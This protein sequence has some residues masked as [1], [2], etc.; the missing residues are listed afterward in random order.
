MQKFQLGSFAFLPKPGK[1][2]QRQLVWSGDP[3]RLN[4]TSSTRFGIKLSTRHHWKGSPTTSARGRVEVETNRCREGQRPSPPS[5]GWGWTRSTGSRQSE[6][7]SSRR[8]NFRL[9]SG[10]QR[11]TLPSTNEHTP[12]DTMPIPHP[13]EHQKPTRTTSPDAHTSSHRSSNHDQIV[14]GRKS[15][16]TGGV[17]EATP[18]S[19]YQPT[20]YSAERTNHL[21]GNRSHG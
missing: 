10:T 13:A 11:A 19:N 14:S 16:P 9:G 2:D 15:S 20:D 17:G 8:H 21:Y 5:T 4:F 6:V 1:T 7:A 18:V 3:N 12:T